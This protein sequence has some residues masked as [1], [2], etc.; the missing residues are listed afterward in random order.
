M[1]TVSIIIPAYCEEAFIGE[2]LRRIREVDVRPLGFE[3][4]IVVV[5]D[6]SKDKTSEV[7]SSFP[8][9]RVIRH[10]VN[11]GKGRAVQ[12]GIRACT[13]DYVLVQDADL[14]YDPRDYLPMLRA[15]AEGGERTV[16]YGSRTRG[17]IARRNGKPWFPGRHPQQSFGPYVAGLLL[18]AW[19]FSLYGKLITDTLTAYK[20][21]PTDAIRALDIKTHGFETDHEITA[22]LLRR[23]YRIVEVPIDYAPRG[24]EEG[25]K[26]KPRDGFVAVWTLLRYRLAD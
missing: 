26:I 15:L 17:T 8:G 11:R 23:G 5:D 22:K 3:M 16:V 9:V 4:E 19:T 1:K 6:C 7:A 18:T 24:V 21:Y 12:T 14:E 13:G 25:K 20:L 2:L 10:E